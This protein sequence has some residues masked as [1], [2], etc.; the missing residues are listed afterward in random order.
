MAE[1]AAKLWFDT[2]QIFFF[3]KASGKALDPIKSL[4]HYVTGNRSPDVKRSLRTADHSPP[5]TIEVE[6]KLLHCPTCLQGVPTDNFTFTTYVE[7]DLVECSICESQKETSLWM[8]F[9]IKKLFSA[10]KEAQ[11]WRYLEP[12]LFVQH[13]CYNLRLKCTAKQDIRHA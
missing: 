11:I 12:F 2:R 8:T 9:L 6:N 7:F 13:A 4:N 3:S 5:S 1:T 10:K